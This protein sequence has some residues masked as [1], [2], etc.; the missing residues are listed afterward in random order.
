VL[1]DEDHAVAD[2]YGAATTP[3]FFVVDAEGVLRYAGAL[4]DVTFRQK[5]PTRQFLA[6]AVAAL[7]EGRLPDP[8][9]TPGYGCAIVRHAG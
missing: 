6:E 4:D 3:H 7:L 8:A 5:T 1:L 9:Q 2:L